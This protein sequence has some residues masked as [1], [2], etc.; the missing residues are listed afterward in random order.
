MQNLHLVALGRSTPLRAA[1]VA[2]VEGKSFTAP[3]GFPTETCLGKSAFAAFLG[4]VQVNV[5]ETLASAWSVGL[6]QGINCRKK[7]KRDNK[8]YIAAIIAN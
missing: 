6:S 8:T 2:L 3:C 7:E 1:D 5:V 4:Q